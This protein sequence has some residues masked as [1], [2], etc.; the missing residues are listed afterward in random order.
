MNHDLELVDRAIFALRVFRNM[1][2]L[3]MALFLLMLLVAVV[4]A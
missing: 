2:I 4:L 1:V 3:P